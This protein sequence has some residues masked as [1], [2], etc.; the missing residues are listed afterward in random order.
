ME[1]QVGNN[2][3]TTNKYI[4]NRGVV[5]QIDGDIIWVRFEKALYAYTAGELIKI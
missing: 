3:K 2:V 5:E 1:F 4:D